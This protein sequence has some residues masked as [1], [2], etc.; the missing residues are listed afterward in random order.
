MKGPSFL[1]LVEY[2]FQNMQSPPPPKKINWQ[3]SALNAFYM[4]LFFIIIGTLG[5][6]QSI[7][8]EDVACKQ[9]G[10]EL[11]HARMIKETTLFIDLLI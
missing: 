9:T 3:A 2:P 1:E 4:A 11:A 8:F 10:R 7:Y 6:A 5:M